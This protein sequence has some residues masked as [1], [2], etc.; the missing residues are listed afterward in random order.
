MKGKIDY[1][2]CKAAPMLEWLGNKWAL[3]ILLT[4][5]EKQPIRFVELYRGIPLL[6]EKVL[7]QTLKQLNVDG[8]IHRQL[9]PDVPPRV[10][11]SITDLGKTLIPYV[12]ALKAWGLENYEQIIQNRKN[13]QSKS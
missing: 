12:E 10:E 8:L 11:Y 4:I 1:A 5:S 7:S 9:Y 3:A 13:F 2:Y 6:S